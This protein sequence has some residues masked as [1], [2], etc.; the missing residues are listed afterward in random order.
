MLGLVIL[1]LVNRK[2]RRCRRKTRR[3]SAGKIAAPFLSSTTIGP[4]SIRSEEV[5]R[6]SSNI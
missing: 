2:E 1:A 5:S 6:H 4:A 3:S